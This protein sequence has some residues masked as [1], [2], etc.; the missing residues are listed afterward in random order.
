MAP[1]DGTANQSRGVGY[2]AT[3]NALESAIRSKRLRHAS[4]FVVG[5]V[6]LGLAMGYAV[7]GVEWSV[8]TQTSPW[9]VAGLAGLVLL[10]LLLTA[11]L[12]WSVTRSFTADPAVKFGA[13][14]SLIAVSGVLNNIPL[15]RAGLWGRAAYLKK[16]HGLAVRDSLLTL[17][18]VLGLA[19]SVLGTMS[20]VLLVMPGPTAGWACAAA[21][22]FQAAIAPRAWA[23]ALRRPTAGAWMWVPL[24]TLD[25][26]A[27]AGR[28][29]LAFSVVSV[30]LTWTN[31][32]LLASAN[33]IVKLVGL[34]PN[35]LGL[36]EW[37]IAALSAAMMPIE[38]ATAA[39]AALIDRAVEVA[40]MLIAAAMGAAW[41]KREATNRVA[42]ENS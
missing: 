24:R 34:T 4:G 42:S 6:L 1:R 32:V 30:E 37:V 13:M 5:L 35:G 27:A 7:R 17:G 9:V 36:S 38:A 10:N 8:V 39:A 21:I 16:Y 2:D 12:F 31:A 33:L 19:V 14:L 25:L 40:V 22:L 20:L 29:G 15:V 23:K 41:L 11:G 26:A 18:I 3:V 28:L